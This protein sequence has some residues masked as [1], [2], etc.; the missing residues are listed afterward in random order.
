M[1]S[2]LGKRFAQVEA[3]CILA[4]I[5]Q[6]YRIELADEKDRSTILESREVLTL[7]P[8]NPVRLKFTPRG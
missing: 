3:V 5:A 2:C 4:L 6:R 7:T 8:V 1:R